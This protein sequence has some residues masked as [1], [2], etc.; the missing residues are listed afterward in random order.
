MWFL[1]NFHSVEFTLL[2]MKKKHKSCFKFN[3]DKLTVLKW[4]C[5]WLFSRVLRPCSFTDDFFFWTGPG[6]TGGFQW[7]P[8]WGPSCV[9]CLVHAG[10]AWETS[11]VM[12]F[13]CLHNICLV[14][15][16]LEVIFLA[17]PSVLGFILTSS[18]LFSSAKEKVFIIIHCK[19]SLLEKTL[20][21]S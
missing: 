16:S 5:F 20:I 11:C 10:E 18:W 12:G 17:E 13:K 19:A 8:W 9:C 14:F 3:L 7:P 15:A 21:M 4:F 6:K 2:R 1:P